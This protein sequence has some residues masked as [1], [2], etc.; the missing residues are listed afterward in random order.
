V[1]YGIA[2]DN[3]WPEPCATCQGNGKLELDFD[4]L[5]DGI[6][7]F[8][9]RH[10]MELVCPV[11]KGK[12]FVLV[13]Q[14]AQKYRYCGG[15]GKLAHYRCFNCQGAGWMFALKERDQYREWR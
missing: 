6:R 4:S 12:A 11:C 2:W 1:E 5:P 14:P 3:Y 13:L 8:V 7:E 15:A 10:Q 9:L